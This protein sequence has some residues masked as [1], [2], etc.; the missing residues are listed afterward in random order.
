MKTSS[1]SIR[2]FIVILLGVYFGSLTIVIVSLAISAKLALDSVGNILLYLGMAIIIFGFLFMGATNRGDGGSRSLRM[3]SDAEFTAWR[4]QERPIEFVT[5]AII[6]AATLMAIT[7]Y[8]LL[9]FVH[10]V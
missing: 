6:L 10:S 1:P 3:R 7:G 8:I 9:Y 2:K 5:W 4:K